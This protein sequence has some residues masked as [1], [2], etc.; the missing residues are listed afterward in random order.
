MGIAG[1][2]YCPSVE[3]KVHYFSD[4]ESHQAFIEPQSQIKDARETDTVYLQGLSTSLPREIQLQVLKTIPGF[5]NSEVAEWGY[6][7]QYDVIDSTQLKITLESKIVKNLFIA[8]QIN[9]TTGYEEAA[10]QG[11]I[12][13]INVHQKIHDLPPLIIYPH[14]AYIGDML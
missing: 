13:G 6:A 4:R 5:E 2:R 8:G 9:G 12:A 1:P 14:Q 7:I 3:H 10:A 11:L